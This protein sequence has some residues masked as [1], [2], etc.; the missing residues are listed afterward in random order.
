VQPSAATSRTRHRA[1]PTPWVWLAA[2]G[3]SRDMSLR[4]SLHDA[5][6]SEELRARTPQ[7]C[8]NGS[9]T[10]P[11][12]HFCSGV[13]RRAPVFAVGF[14]ASCES[15]A[16]SWRSRPLPRRHQRARPARL[17]PQLRDCHRPQTTSCRGALL[18]A[19]RSCKQQFTTRSQRSARSRASAGEST[20][21]LWILPVLWPLVLARS[22]LGRLR[23]PHS[24]GVGATW[25][26]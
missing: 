14:R 20:S 9:S 2:R 5:D 18:S 23:A 17:P 8:S 4:A 10:S 26:P 16:T 13:R 6:N 11:T 22:L 12:L 3:C 25:T 1:T 19:G 21:L 24:D 7:D 15:A